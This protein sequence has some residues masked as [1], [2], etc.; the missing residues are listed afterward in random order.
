MNER[1]N[2]TESLAL[3][4]SIYEIKCKE[5]IKSIIIFFYEKINNNM[6][7]NNRMLKK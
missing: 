7:Y 6:I 4:F 3:Y 5:A 2:W 1:F